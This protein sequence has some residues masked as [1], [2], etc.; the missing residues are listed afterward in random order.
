[1]CCGFHLFHFH[2]RG[3]FLLFLPLGVEMSNSF[4]EFPC[5]LMDAMRIIGSLWDTIS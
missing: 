4:V 1:M 2:S 5:L 3:Q